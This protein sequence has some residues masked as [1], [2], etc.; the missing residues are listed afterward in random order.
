MQQ[1]KL[2]QFGDLTPSDFDRYP[3]WI[4]CHTVDSDEPWYENTDEETFRPWTGPLPVDPSEGML[5]VR[6]TIELNDR[7][8]Y[9]GFVTPAFEAGD[10]GTQQPQIFVQGRRFGLWGGM[11][12]VP[13]EERTAMYDALGKKADAVFPLRFSADPAVAG[14]VAS[15]LA[16]G[17]YRLSD[18]GIEIEQ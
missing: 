9:E 11:F 6:A 7:T 15:G 14:G 4:A 2:R 3:V 1:P 13:L 10:L 12:G 17:F 5:L 18:T 16:A 8:R